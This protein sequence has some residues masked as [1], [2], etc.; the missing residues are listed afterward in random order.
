[1]DRTISRRVCSRVIRGQ[2]WPVA[3]PAGQPRLISGGNSRA[4]DDDSA[5]AEWEARNETDERGGLRTFPHPESM[6]LP[7]SVTKAL[8]FRPDRDVE[9]I[10]DDDDDDKEQSGGS[11]PQLQDH[12][13]RNRPGLLRLP[14]P[15]GASSMRTKPL[16]TTARDG[17]GGLD[18]G[19]LMRLHALSP[20]G[21]RVHDGC[22]FR[23]TTEWGIFARLVSRSRTAGAGLCARDLKQPGDATEAP[24]DTATRRRL[25]K[26]TSRA[27]ESPLRWAK[28]R[29]HYGL[30]RTRLSAMGE[31]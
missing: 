25:R 29:I 22:D 30:D 5:Q 11:S 15:R 3:E 26:T 14:P 7:K 20:G 13:G 8:R 21:E 9:I 24:E 2:Y 6:S 31:A 4:D 19:K 23:H 10:S 12:I 1:M 18:W 27:N 16:S 28:N 17:P